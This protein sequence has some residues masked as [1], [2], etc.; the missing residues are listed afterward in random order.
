VFERFLA[1]DCPLGRFQRAP[2]VFGGLKLALF[3]SPFKLKPFARRA[4]R[5]RSAPYSQAWLA[6][7]PPGRTPHLNVIAGVGCGVRGPRPSR[8][9]IHFGSSVS[10][11]HNGNPPRTAAARTGGK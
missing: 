4:R 2:V 11:A 8:T 10:R 1:L 5:E 3:L 7:I 9:A 6:Q